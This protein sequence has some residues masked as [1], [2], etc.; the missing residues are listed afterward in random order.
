MVMKN[1]RGLQLAIETVI[2]MVLAVALL[3]TLFGFWAYQKGIFGDFLRQHGD[4]PNVDELISI[5]NSLVDSEASYEYCCV[6]KKI[7][8]MENDEL[9]EKELTCEKLAAESYVSERINEMECEDD[10]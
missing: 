2:I 4:K 3:L 10:C 9:K 8:Y 6:N 5:C 1:K 7:K